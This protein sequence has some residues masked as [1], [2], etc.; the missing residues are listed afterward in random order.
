[1]FLLSI[2]KLLVLRAKHGDVSLFC[3]S[4]TY[5]C[6]QKTSSLM[7]LLAL[8]IK[9]KALIVILRRISFTLL[10]KVLIFFAFII[11]FRFSNCPYCCLLSPLACPLKSTNCAFASI[12]WQ[13]PSSSTTTANLRSSV[14]PCSKCLAFFSSMSIKSMDLMRQIFT[15]SHIQLMT[16][17][18]QCK[19]LC[20]LLILDTYGIIL[21]QKDSLNSF[22]V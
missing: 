1:M 5:I 16:S 3:T 11:H 4:K 2:S 22:Y 18:C 17:L 12:S 21:L 13:V 6:F 15:Y 10:W 9:W 14:Y 20:F 19:K 8:A 7:A